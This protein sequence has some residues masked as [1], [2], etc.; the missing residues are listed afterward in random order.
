MAAKFWALK[1]VTQT[2]PMQNGWREILGIRSHY[3]IVISLFVMRQLLVS[4]NTPDDSRLSWGM[5]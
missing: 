2:N 1:F 5:R 3:I 4:Q